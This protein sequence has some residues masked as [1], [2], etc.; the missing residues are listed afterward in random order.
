MTAPSYKLLYQ[1]ETK[2]AV[3][4][5]RGIDRNGKPIFAY[6]HSSKAQFLA[7]RK[8][9]EARKRINFCDYG[10]IVAAGDGEPDDA[11]RRYMET[12]Y[13]DDA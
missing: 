11:L 12:D 10:E 6:M 8:A 9:I 2:D 3:M 5:V 4:L 13:A 1:L 7:L